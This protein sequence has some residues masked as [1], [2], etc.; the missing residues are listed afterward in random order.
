MKKRGF[1]AGKWN[2][3]GGKVEAGET[4]EDAAKRELREECGIESINM[5][6]IGLLDFKFQSDPKIFETHIF[7]VSEFKGEPTE[8][9]EM[10][11]LWFEEGAIPYNEMWSD[12]ILWLPILLK[13]KKFKGE[14]LFDRPSDPEY[15]AKIIEQ[16]LKEVDSI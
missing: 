6:K 9:E 13:K 1:G 16:I 14:F 4:I 8:T 11:P 5:E 3:F 2:G 10:N 7:H 12:D 15:S